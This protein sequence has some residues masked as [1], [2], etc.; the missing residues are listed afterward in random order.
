MEILFFGNLIDITR[1]PKELI[2]GVADTAALKQLLEKKYQPLQTAKYFIAV[3][4]KMVQEN[5]ILNKGDTVALMPPF[6]GG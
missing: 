1:Q 4:G 5:T 3:N 6:S 2:E